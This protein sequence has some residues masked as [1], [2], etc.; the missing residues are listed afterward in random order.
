[1]NKVPPARRLY[2]SL[3]DPNYLVLD[4]RRRLLKKEIQQIITVNKSD[5][6]LLDIGG[7]KKPYAPLFSPVTRQHIALDLWSRSADLIGVGECL[8]FASD[9]IDLVLCT[10]ILEHVR[11]PVAITDE[12]YRVLKPGGRVFVSV[13]AVFPLHGSPE[14]NWRFMSGEFAY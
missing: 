2:P 9:S 12:I 7:S 5:L 3:K 1:M 14:D 8:S 4:S 11:R 10:Q 13:P 6:T